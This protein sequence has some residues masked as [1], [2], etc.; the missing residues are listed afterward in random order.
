MERPCLVSL[1]V[2]VADNGVI[3]ADNSIPWKCSSDMRYFRNTTMGKPVIMGR[4]TWDS[5]G[6]P[7]KGRDNI[8]LTRNDGFR[9]EG[10]HIV[11][12][13]P[14]A[15][16]LASSF[17]KPDQHCEVMIIGGN[18][19]YN[20]FITLCERIYYSQIH[21]SPNGDTFFPKLERLLDEGW[22]EVSR[23]EQ[24]ARERDEADMSF[25]VLEK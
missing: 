11:T 2:A 14:L 6:K 25:I 18:A 3:G 1:I 12:S 15:L 9:V 4:K 17:C 19:V 23:Q 13:G 16:K 20:E 5:L 7:L 10:A 21:M 22:R 8:V 24:A